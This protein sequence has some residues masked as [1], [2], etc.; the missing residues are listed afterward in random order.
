MLP[1]SSDMAH[2]LVLSLEQ[3]VPNDALSE[4]IS[5]LAILPSKTGFL[6]EL[7]PKCKQ[8]LKL[9]MNRMHSTLK[10]LLLIGANFGSNVGDVISILQLKL[11]L[12]YLW[13]CSFKSPDLIWS[14][15]SEFKDLIEL[16]HDGEIRGY[17]FAIPFNGHTTRTVFN[18]DSSLL[19]PNSPVFV[20]VLILYL[21]QNLPDD[22]LLPTILLQPNLFY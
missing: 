14:A 2:G 3:D 22:F 4:N 19:L 21:G 11:D 7:S 5:F 13:K 6:E 10:H 9:M 12:I 20:H 18:N 17:Q 1:I 8:G 16:L 15:L